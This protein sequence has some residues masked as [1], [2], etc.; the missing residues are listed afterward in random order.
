MADESPP[1]L[2]LPSAVRPTHY[3]VA[4]TVVP[5]QAKVRG[6]A[7][8]DIALDAPQATLWLNANRLA[9]ARVDVD[10]DAARARVKG[11]DDQVV[12]L[13]FDSPLRAG[14]HRLTLV[15]EAEQNTQ[16]S[17]GIFTLEDQ[18]AWY[19]M[20]QFEPTS[21]RRAFP[22]F[23][24]PS[25]KVPW[26]LTLRVPRDLVAVANAP[27]KTERDIGDGMKEVVF[28]ESRPLP[29]Y[30]VAFAVGPFDVVDAGSVTAR[31]CVSSR[32]VA[33]GP[34]SDSPGRRCPN[35][36][37]AKRAGSPFPIRTRSSTTS[38]FR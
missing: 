38:R 35:S 16:S 2:R 23:D 25:F 37:R 26:Q 32:R 24:E 15:Y 11:G 20:T 33:G 14:R 3:D 19:T 5:G 8:I 12:G 28:A 34:T 17:R 22:C 27:V 31:R 6:Q 18:G 7:A 9:I 13:A 10:G 30:L 21:A 36:S 4:L 1:R 29:S